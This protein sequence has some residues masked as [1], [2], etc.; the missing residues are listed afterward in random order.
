MSDQ[1]LTFR[2]ARPH[3]GLKGF[4]EAFEFREILD[5]EDTSFAGEPMLETILG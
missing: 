3:A 2:R 1:D 5:G 4:D